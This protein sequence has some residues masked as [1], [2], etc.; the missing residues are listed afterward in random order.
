MRGK[1]DEMD[2]WRAARD[3]VR[4]D[5]ARPGMKTGGAYADPPLAVSLFD[6]RGPLT[7]PIVP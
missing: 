5:S 6:L 4:I 3:K 1:A 2:V 7:R